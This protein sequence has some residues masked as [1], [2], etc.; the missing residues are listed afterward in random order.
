[1]KALKTNWLFCLAAMFILVAGHSATL[2]FTVDGTA[3]CSQTGGVPYGAKVEVFDIDPLPGNTYHTDAQPL[4]V[5][6]VDENG[7]FSVTFDWTTGGPDFEVGGPDLIFRVAQNIGGTVEFICEEAP[8]DAHW[9]VSTGAS[10]SINITAAQAVCYLDPGTIPDNKDFLFTRIGSKEVAYLSNDPSKPAVYGY[11]R[12]RADGYTGIDTDVPFGSSL[13]LFGWVGEGSDANCYQLL[14][15][16]DNGSTWSEWDGNLSSKWYDTPN[17]KWVSE[18]MGPFSPGPSGSPTNLYKIPYKVNTKTWSYIDL[19]ARFNSQL[20]PDGLCKF[21]IKGYIWDYDEN[22]AATLANNL[23]L[24][25]SL[26]DSKIALRIDNSPPTVQ[27]LDLKLNGASQGVCKILTFET[28]DNISVEF[29]VWDQNGHLRSYAL[30]AMY[31]HDC[32]VN[33]KPTNASANYDNNASGS[34]S[35]QGN[36]SYKTEYSGSGYGPG[37]I[38]PT[39]DCFSMPFAQM[40]DNVMPTCA[41]QFRLHASKRTTNGYGLIYHGVEDTW[42]V[43]IQRP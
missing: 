25:T 24:D 41:Y 22:H 9:N 40:P 32:R 19:I 17:Y 4:G 11:Y 39:T 42:H 21:K 31:G 2:A 16:V 6:Y 14:Y 37:G 38:S 23:E 20:V 28:N 26:P 34:P 43:T 7:H 1:M 8:A 29:R 18:K 5:D 35:W 3:T 33:P 10:F 36:M 15:S 13:E 30:D 27:I 12:A